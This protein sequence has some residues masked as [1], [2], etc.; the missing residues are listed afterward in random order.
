VR[1]QGLM[2]RDPKSVFRVAAVGQLWLAGTSVARPCEQ[3][4]CLQ[5]CRPTYLQQLVLSWQGW[6]KLACG[7]PQFA[8]AGAWAFVCMLPY[9][10]VVSCLGCDGAEALAMLQALFSKCMPAA[11]AGVGSQRAL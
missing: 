8:S 6:P 7:L 11:S 2:S 3:V 4:T 10:F 1:A 9:L 5:H